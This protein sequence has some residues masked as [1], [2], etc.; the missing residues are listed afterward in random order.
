M[1]LLTTLEVARFVADGYVRFDAV[2]P[3]D[4][5][6]AAIDDL[7]SFAT[8]PPHEPSPLRPV[9]G[10]PL[11]QC[12]PP[13]S[14]LRA[15]V[16]VPE[17]AG[18][19]HSLVGPEPVFDHAAVHHNRSGNRF[20]QGLHADAAIDSHDPT[21]DIQVFWF[22]HDVGP[23]EGGTRFVPGSHVRNV[24]ESSVAR[25][26]HLL[27]EQRFV[28]PAGSVL[29][30]HSGLWHAG[31][32]NRSER[33]RW[34]YK[35]RL[36]PTVP[37]VRHWDTADYDEV[38]SGSWDHRFA[39]TAPGPTVADELRRTHPWSFASE[40]RLELIQRVRLWRYLSGDPTFDVDWYHRRIEDRA[41][42]LD[43]PTR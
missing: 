1:H 38:T 26:Q 18:A 19:I 8:T 28:G 16:E 20:D 2:V 21:F 10:T 12:Y 35:L 6:R 27:G 32:T 15:L 39:T 24:H 17:V 25:Y 40:Y 42:L 43:G 34:M 9:S 31:Q 4:V 37:Q 11:S 3:D 5:N 30:F 22:P 7:R 29:I 14:A 33:D 23:G 13:G 36:N 41:A